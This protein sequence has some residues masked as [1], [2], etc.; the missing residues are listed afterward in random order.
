MDR[1]NRNVVGGISI[2]T[3]ISVGELSLLLG[4][5][6]VYQLERLSR[7]ANGDITVSYSLSYAGN[8]VEI[9][10]VTSCSGMNLWLLPATIT[11]RAQP[12]LPD[13]D[14]QSQVRRNAWC[15]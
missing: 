15:R 8:P 9:G 11:Y 13:V 14:W 4:K 7:G 5:M 6:S 2:P 12:I 3:R 10:G 1:S